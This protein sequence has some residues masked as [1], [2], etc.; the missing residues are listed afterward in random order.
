MEK[1]FQEWFCIVSK[2]PYKLH[3]GQ[4]HL[5][6]VKNKNLLT[7]FLS[8]VNCLWL[9]EEIEKIINYSEISIKVRKV[10]QKYTHKYVHKPI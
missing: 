2:N 8:S 10:G 6:F 7:Y 1:H 3:L 9:M 5:K 4:I